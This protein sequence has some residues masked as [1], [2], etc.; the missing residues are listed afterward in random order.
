[1][2]IARLRLSSNASQFS[3]NNAVEVDADR[4]RKKPQVLRGHPQGVD[5]GPHPQFRLHLAAAA[6]Q[7][8]DGAF[9]GGDG[10]HRPGRRAGRQLCLTG[11]RVNGVVRYVAEGDGG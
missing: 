6:G 7:M 10:P 5:F 2:A 4:I 9:H 1:L 11:R 3:G 8:A